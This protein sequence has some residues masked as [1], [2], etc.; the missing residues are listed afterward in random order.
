MLALASTVAISLFAVA[1]ILLMLERRRRPAAAHLPSEAMDTVEAWP[2]QAVRVMT[3]E[4][5]H[6][7]EIV[8]RAMPKHLVLAQV[9][10]A[11]FISVPT[12]HSYAEWLQRAG[13]LNV[14]LLITDTSSR[15]VA[16]VEIHASDETPR[17][18]KRHKR[19]A[20]VL[21]AAG[22]R[23]HIWREDA[24]PTPE[25]AMRQLR[26]DDI[27]GYDD[28]SDR[29]R[30]PIPVAEVKELLNAGDRVDYGHGRDPV[31]STFFDD[32]DAL[33]PQKS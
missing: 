1:M 12:K 13:R 28:E 7:Y 4:E 2:P 24:L 8:R 17:S 15:P 25:Q 14:D 20:E 31:A 33:V 30:G 3:L 21:Q 11:R 5:R 16:A 10:L 26:G 32:L 18:V 6:A 9:P 22:I 19:L 23:V 29:Q 27:A